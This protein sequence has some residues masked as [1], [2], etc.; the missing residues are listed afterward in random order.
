MIG[1]SGGT[2]EQ[3]RGY[4]YNSLE[5]RPLKLDGEAFVDVLDW[6][7]EY[8]INGW[9]LVANPYGWY[10]DLEVD[11]N[12]VPFDEEAYRES[13]RASGLEADEDFIEQEKKWSKPSMEFWRWN[14]EKSQYEQA[15]ILKPYEAVWVKLN[16][17]ASTKT[18]EAKP[19]YLGTVEEDGSLK[20]YEAYK[21]LNRRLAKASG[22]SGWTLQLVLSDSKGKMDSWNVLG[23]GKAAWD[24]EEPPAG[25][26]DR[27][28]LSILNGGKRLAK[29][30]RAET[31]ACIRMERGTV[32][33]KRPQG[34][35]GGRGCRCPARK[36]PARIRDLRRQHTR[37]PYGRKAPGRTRPH[38]Q[39]CVNPRGACGQEPDR[40]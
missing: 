25:M 27:V 10:L 26:G 19:F 29:S 20:R 24:S 28:N 6:N 38:G 16:H 32:G 17:G 35:P 39:D 5:G 34:V 8:E 31:E 21:S 7:L 22:E 9:N 13:M 18:L 3:G 11:T 14:G 2:P 1:L 12:Y 33:H 4:W 15:R 36:G 30:V 37:N 23:A 40:A